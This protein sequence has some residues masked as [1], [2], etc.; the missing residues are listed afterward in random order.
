MG[1]DRNIPRPVVVPIYVVSGRLHKSRLSAPEW[2]ARMTDGN[3]RRV[4]LVPAPGMCPGRA[5]AR[6]SG[7]QVLHC[8]VDDTAVDPDALAELFV[9]PSF[10]RL[11]LRVHQN[12]S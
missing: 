7:A 6:V 1:K 4:I 9:L 2:K 10:D 5:R 8:P 11:G 3:I 12:T